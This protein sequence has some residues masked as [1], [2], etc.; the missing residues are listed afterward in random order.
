MGS[1][2]LV[3]KR[4]VNTPKMITSS[5]RRLLYI[6]I[7]ALC[8]RYVY[9]K[10]IDYNRKLDDTRSLD[11]LGGANLMRSLDTL[12]G[13][14]L[15]RNL[16]NFGGS[17]IERQQLAALLHDRHQPLP[18]RFDSLGG[19]GFGAPAKKKFDEIDRTGFGSFWKKKR[20]FDEIDRSGFGSF[21]KK[22]NFDEIDRS[23]FGNFWKRSADGKAAEEE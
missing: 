3:L 7:F 21:W 23:G 17:N 11:S 5:Q 19:T 22:R 16:D 4:R 8:C 12:G 15:V 2:Y 9:G 14:N 10:Q 6:S 20:N 13:N 1:V 18:K